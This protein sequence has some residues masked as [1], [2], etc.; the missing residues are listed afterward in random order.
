M[1][2]TL[3]VKLEVP[4]DELRASPGGRAILRDHAKIAIV[5]RKSPLHKALSLRRLATDLG[6]THLYPMS[7]KVGGGLL[8]VFA[9]CVFGR[10]PR[11]TLS[12]ILRA[13]FDASLAFDI[14]GAT[15]RSCLVT[16]G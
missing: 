4:D 3:V 16:F 7:A 13:Y 9:P 5:G 2:L 1:A 6:A 8:T 14:C 10:K 15:P 12:V 11:E